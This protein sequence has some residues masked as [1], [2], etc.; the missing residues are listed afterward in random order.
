MISSDQHEIDVCEE[1]RFMG[2]LNWCQQCKSSRTVVKMV[3]PYAA[4][5]LIQE[6]MNMDIAA[7]MQLDDEFRQEGEGKSIGHID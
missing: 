2:Y 4:K 5:L 3:V 7:R 6:L 1:C